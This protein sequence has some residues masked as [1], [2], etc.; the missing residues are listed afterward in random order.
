MQITDVIIGLTRLNLLVCSCRHWLHVPDMAVVVLVG[1]TSTRHRCLW[2]QALHSARKQSP[3]AP[4]IKKLSDKSTT[5]AKPNLFHVLKSH[6]PV[7]QKQAPILRPSAPA[8]APTLASLSWQAQSSV[9]LAL[10]QFPDGEQQTRPSNC[11]STPL[12]ESCS[13]PT[14]RLGQPTSRGLPGN[15]CSRLAS[16][17]LLSRDH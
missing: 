3:N 11:D 1:I 7:A 16:A 13:G 6:A 9:A 12:S 2:A 5:T 10:A 14:P 15:V 17:Q 8:L 4:G